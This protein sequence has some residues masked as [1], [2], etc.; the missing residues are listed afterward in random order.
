MSRTRTGTGVTSAV[1]WARVGAACVAILMLISIAINSP[2]AIASGASGTAGAAAPA[3]ALMAER[4]ISASDMAELIEIATSV[5]PDLGRTLTEARDKN[6]DAFRVAVGQSG[7]RLQSLL[8]LKRL[9]P[10]VY[11]VR[12]VEMRLEGEA[13]VLGS[14]LRSATEAGRI[15]DANDLEAKLREVGKRLVDQNLRARG[16]ELAELDLAVKS[17]RL[18]LERDAKARA[19]TLD[20]MVDAYRTGSAV[21]HLGGRAPIGTTSTA[22]R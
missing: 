21:P 19:T 1:L 18:E 6:P 16:L 14:Q 9:R 12:V 5:S 15:D 13:S 7:K 22:A 3:G 4:E 17:M 20:S 2:S 10:A 11:E 8:I